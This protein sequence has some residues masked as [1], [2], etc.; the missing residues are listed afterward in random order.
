MKDEPTGAE[1]QQTMVNLLHYTAA[2]ACMTLR[3]SVDLSFARHAVMNATFGEKGHEL[4]VSTY[5]MVILLR[6]NEADWRVADLR[7]HHSTDAII[8]IAAMQTLRPNLARS[9]MS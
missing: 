6:S 7:H 2:V 3:I 5:Q 8:I 9:G 1:W 4:N